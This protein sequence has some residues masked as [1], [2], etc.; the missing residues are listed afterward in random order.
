MVADSQ[1]VTEYKE[2]VLEDRRAQVETVV[3]VDRDRLYKIR[4]MIE[5]AYC[6]QGAHLIKGIDLAVKTIGTRLQDK[7][8]NRAPRTAEFR[9][10]V[11]GGGI[12]SRED[13]CGRNVHLQQ[14]RPLVVV[15]PFKLQIICEPRIPI[16]L[17]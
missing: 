11:A 16:D 4:A 8:R 12:H 17:R 5:K 6:L 7:I 2:L 10:I 1:E 3:V 14:S 15:D 9:L 13:L